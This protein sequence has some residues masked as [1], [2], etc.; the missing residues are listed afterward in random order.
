MLILQYLWV[1]DPRAN[2]G[3]PLDHAG[4]DDLALAGLTPLQQSRHDPHRTGQPT[5]GKIGQ[6]VDGS[7]RILRLPT[8]TGQ[9][10]GYGQIV[11]IVA[12]LK[13]KQ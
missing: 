2:I 12:F 11:D 7:R 13:H 10:S 6:Q 3:R 1:K 8:E 4:I 5:S 9:D